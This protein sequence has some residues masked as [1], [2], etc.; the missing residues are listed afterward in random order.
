MQPGI[1]SYTY[2]WAVGVPGSLP[3]RPFSVYDLIDKAAHTQ[4]NL[5]QIA[6]NLSLENLTKKN[7]KKYIFTLATGKVT[8]E[9][10]S[11]GLTAETYF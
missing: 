5:V 9:F 10:G 11:R 6:D 1:S 2:T 4:V 3:E 8:M 7:L